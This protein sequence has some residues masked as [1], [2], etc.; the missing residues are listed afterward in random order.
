M[1]NIII[2]SRL[3]TLSVLKIF[4]EISS[5][6]FSTCFLS[7]SEITTI[8]DEMIRN[9]TIIWSRNGIPGIINFIAAETGIERIVP[10]SAAVEVVRFQNI[11]NT[12]IAVIPGLIIPVYS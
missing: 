11:P 10:Q 3:K 8:T 6:L 2:A 1:I 7:S 9:E 12:K 5:P 4:R